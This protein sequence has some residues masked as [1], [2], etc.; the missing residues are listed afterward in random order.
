MPDMQTQPKFYL[1]AITILDHAQAAL[2]AAGEAAAAYLH[3]H[4]FKTPDERIAE[5]EPVV[6][7]YRLSQGATLIV[8]TNAARTQTVVM[9]PQD[10]EADSA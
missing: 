10:R 2:A 7:Q 3:A 9:T 1:G 6:N 4:A 8:I 5:D